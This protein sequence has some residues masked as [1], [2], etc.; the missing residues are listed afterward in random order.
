MAKRR[1]PQSNIRHR[2]DDDAG[3]SHT[4]IS[5]DDS[6][7]EEEEDPDEDDDTNDDDDSEEE[8]EDPHV[9]EPDTEHDSVRP[10][11]DR[12]EGDAALSLDARSP[13]FGWIS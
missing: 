13:R 7:E 10:A 11:L 12:S 6:E 1:T 2:D 5:S 9:D 3:A 4:A 8:E